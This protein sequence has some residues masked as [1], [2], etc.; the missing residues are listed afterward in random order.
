MKAPDVSHISYCAIAYTEQSTGAERRGTTLPPHAVLLLSAVFSVVLDILSQSSHARNQMARLR[1]Q[2]AD[3]IPSSRRH[4]QN[5]MD[6]AHNSP[7]PGSSRPFLVHLLLERVKLF[8]SPGGLPGGHRA[9]VSKL[10]A[11]L[12]SCPYSPC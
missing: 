11:E 6:G 7:S 3:A 1:I 9:L 12:W 10:H 5:R 4:N 2:H 8:P